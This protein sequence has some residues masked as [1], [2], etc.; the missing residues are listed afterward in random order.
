MQGRG[1]GHP[2]VR[3]T[4][5]RQRTQN[6]QP[7]GGGR[8][9]GGRGRG[10]HPP[11]WSA[12]PALLG[13]TRKWGSLVGPLITQTGS[14]GS[15]RGLPKSTHGCDMAQQAARQSCLPAA[16]VLRGTEADASGCWVPGNT[17]ILTLT[18]GGPGGHHGAPQELMDDCVPWRVPG[19]GP[20]REHGCACHP[21]MGG[22]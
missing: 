21:H 16:C 9:G 10:L 4:R 7:R 11:A 8:A 19:R 17:Q 12:S 13:R 22:R 3:S 5:M 6:R 20:S 14:P 18:R 2:Q 15:G 1:W